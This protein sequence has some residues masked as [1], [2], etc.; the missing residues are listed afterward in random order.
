LERK[1]KY[2]I[3]VVH[4][5]IA[6]LYF[7]C[8]ENKPIE[9]TTKPKVILSTT[10]IDKILGDK[11]LDFDKEELRE[12]NFNDLLGY[13]RKDL[14]EESKLYNVKELENEIIRLSQVKLYNE[15]RNF[16]ILLRMDN[17]TVVDFL[18]INDERI[19]DFQFMNDTIF[20]LTQN[21]DIHKY[22]KK[23]N[24]LN[25]YA[26]NS[27]LEFF[28]KY[29]S[30]KDDLSVDAV[31]FADQNTQEIVFK[32]K[33]SIASTEVY[34]VYHIYLNKTGEFVKSNYILSINTNRATSDELLERVFKSVGKG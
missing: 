30:R 19:R 14:L 6:L 12:N 27:D 7:N 23:A 34:D 25:V 21:I 17:D 28:W 1:A 31:S 26:I 22:W 29:S 24:G 9:S 15:A 5:F 11:V 3:L 4:C 10:K 2:I 8:S 18:V 32:V 13:S 33:L 20:V 16:E